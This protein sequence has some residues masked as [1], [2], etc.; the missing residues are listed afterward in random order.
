MLG[1]PAFGKGI[2]GVSVVLGGLGLVA[3]VL[4]MVDPASMVGVVSYFAIII[5]CFVLG[6]KVYS[7]SRTPEG[8]LKIGE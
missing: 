5:F 6:W 8:V 7:L 1:A 4:Q 3:A 2:G